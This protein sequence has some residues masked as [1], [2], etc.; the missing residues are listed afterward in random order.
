MEI[1]AV[2]AQ[3]LELA[4]DHRLQPDR[5]APQGDQAL[6]GLDGVVESERHP[7]V[8]MLEVELAAVLVVSVD[9]VRSRAARNW[10]ARLSTSP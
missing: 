4:V 6:E 5:P 1:H 10:S 7:G 3:D 9:D 2:V 8:A